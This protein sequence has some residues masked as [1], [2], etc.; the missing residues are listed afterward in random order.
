MKRAHDHGIMSG[1]AE[2]KQ[3][4]KKRYRGGITVWGQ[5]Q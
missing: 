5:G 3:R 1:K 2:R 4:V